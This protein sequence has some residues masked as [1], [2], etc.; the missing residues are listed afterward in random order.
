MFAGFKSALCKGRM[1]V[2]MAAY[3]DKVDVNICKQT[4]GGLMVFDGWIVDGAVRTCLCSCWICWR[5]RPLHKRNDVQFRV[6]IYERQ[7]ETFCGEAVAD[8]TNSD[9]LGH[10]GGLCWARSD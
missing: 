2:G 6:C 3:D 5:G 4:F 8:D 1:R 7:M 9:L 10:F